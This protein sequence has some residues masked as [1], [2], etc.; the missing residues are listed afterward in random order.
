MA[1]LLDM[2]RWP[3]QGHVMNPQRK[4]YLQG[5]MAG[6]N[7]SPGIGQDGI[8]RDPQVNPH[9]ITIDVNYDDKARDALYSN[10][11][12]SQ[13]QS[14]TIN[15]PKRGLNGLVPKVVGATAFYEANGPVMVWSAGP[16]RMVDPN[17]PPNQG[18]NKDDIVSWK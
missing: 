18:A 3:N 9:V 6:N 8:Y 15:V 1:V 17:P 2:D 11:Q 14:D 12:V 4:Q 7:S 10:Q 13:D 5:T 16:D